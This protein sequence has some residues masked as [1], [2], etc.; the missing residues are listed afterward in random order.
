MRNEFSQILIIFFI[1]HSVFW[2]T[3]YE[4]MYTINNIYNVLSYT[5][6]SRVLKKKLY[7]KLANKKKWLK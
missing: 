4:Q 5:V 1:I 2:G 7:L 3:M 6:A